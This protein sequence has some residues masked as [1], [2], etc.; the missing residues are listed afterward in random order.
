M[1]DRLIGSVHKM[2]KEEFYKEDGKWDFNEDVS[3]V[4]EDMLSRSIPQYEEMRR[5]V[6]KIGKVFLDG[7]KS[8]S[9]LEIGCSDGLNLKAFVEEYGAH[10]RFVGVDISTPMLEKARERYKGYIESGI[11]TIKKMDLREDFPLDIYALIMSVLSLQFIPIE[12][13]Q[14]IVQKIYDNLEKGSAFIMVEKVLGGSHVLNTI[15]VDEYYRL[16]GENGYSHDEI[17]RKKISLEG[18]LVPMTSGWNKDILRQAG[19]RQVDTFW[20]WMN[21]EGYLAIK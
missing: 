10:K 1:D 19:F 15:M 4:F 5:L 12:Y 11:V 2:T 17:N 6:F 14:M 20:R 8:G 18:V 7:K 21:F 13:R 3:L 9:V 16:K